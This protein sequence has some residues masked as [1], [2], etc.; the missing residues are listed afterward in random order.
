MGIER[1]K[2]KKLYYRAFNCLS[3][4]ANQ[5]EQMQLQL[6]ELYLELEDGFQPELEEDI[7]EE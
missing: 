3:D 6:E 1:E 4:L 2:Y 5:I 7:R